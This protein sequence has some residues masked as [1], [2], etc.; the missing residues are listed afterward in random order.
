MKK[1]KISI[2]ATPLVLVCGLVSLGTSTAAQSD[3]QHCSCS[4]RTLFGEY[5]SAAEG[6]LL[7]PVAPSETQFRS[8][9]HDSF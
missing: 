9:R 8:G 4:N 3:D 6:V 7:P 2:L 5:G 1:Q